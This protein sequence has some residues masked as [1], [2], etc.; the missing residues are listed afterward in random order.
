[1]SLCFSSKSHIVMKRGD[2]P[3]LIHTFSAGA[4]LSLGRWATVFI[5]EG[6]NNGKGKIMGQWYCT[7]SEKRYGPVETEVLREWIVQG[8][9]RPEDSVWTEGM[10]EWL[11]A[12]QVSGLFDGVTV[13]PPMP[14][15]PGAAE[16]PKAPG[17]VASMVLGITSVCFGAL[18]LVLGIIALKCS[19]QARRAIAQHP[20]RY[21]GDDMATAGKVM[22]IIGIVVG[23]F[24]VAYILFVFTMFATFAGVAA[25][26]AA[27]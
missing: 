7:I 9:C 27:G 2:Q 16:R 11:P 14:A 17:A 12:E 8:R 5:L 19:K 3:R 4:C 10:E 24:F 26:S 13:P 22:G 1:M 21:S 23:S 6:K 20:G 15:T 18:G 25:S